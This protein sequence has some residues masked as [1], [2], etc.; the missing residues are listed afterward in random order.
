M[1]MDNAHDAHATALARWEQEGGATPSAARVTD[2]VR[3][4]AA[5]HQASARA[6]LDAAHDSSAR[7][8]HRYP[9]AQQTAAERDARDGRDDFKRRMAYR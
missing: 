3:R 5:A 6:T 9:D 4:D 2:E 7:G 1:D 8:E